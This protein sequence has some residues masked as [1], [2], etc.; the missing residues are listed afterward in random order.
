MSCSPLSPALA[1]HLSM[2]FLRLLLF[3]S[4]VNF[5]RK[6]VWKARKSA[7]MTRCSGQSNVCWTSAGRAA[8]SWLPRWPPAGLTTALVL[9][10]EVG[11]RRLSGRVG[12][13]RRQAAGRPE[14]TSAGMSEDVGGREWPGNG[15]VEVSGSS[16]ELTGSLTV[17]HSH[18]A[19]GLAPCAIHM[20]A[21]QHTAPDAI[22]YPHRQSV[23][24]RDGGTRDDSGGRSRWSLGW[25]CHA[26]EEDRRG[27]T[28]REA[29]VWS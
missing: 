17:C 14:W 10:S 28:R 24:R 11:G 6:G 29:T 20:R 22:T 5:H 19:T 13:K 26:E 3:S 2:P 23:F 25:I 4:R 8:A 1:S 16:G 27:Q 15:G 12:M 18:I 21:C 7:H 9:S